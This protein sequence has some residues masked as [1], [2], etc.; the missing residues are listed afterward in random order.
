MTKLEEQIAEAMKDLLEE[1]ETPDIPEPDQE[2][3]SERVERR[4]KKRDTQDNRES[5]RLFRRWR[6]QSGI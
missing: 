5:R 6:K 3:I 2:L 1:N 4:Q